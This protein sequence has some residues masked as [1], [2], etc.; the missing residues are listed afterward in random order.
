MNC[1]ILIKE[2]TSVALQSFGAKI[3]ID[4]ELAANCIIP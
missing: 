2:Q 1:D 3:N 4:K